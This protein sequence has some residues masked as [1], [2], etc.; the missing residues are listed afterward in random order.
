MSN[1]KVVLV[2]AYG[3]GEGAS[4]QTNGVPFSLVVEVLQ[5]IC[6]GLSRQIVKEAEADVSDDQVE[7]Y[8]DAI[9]A[10][11]RL[12]LEQLLR[13][14]HSA[15]STPQQIADA[16]DMSPVFVARLKELFDKSHRQGLSS[17]EWNEYRAKATR[18]T[19]NIMEKL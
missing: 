5:T 4:I 3:E 14:S 10:T 15:I 18:F 8:I 12:K 1:R 2:L 6:K 11:D 16:F 13:E 7:A 9:V 19:D 17:V